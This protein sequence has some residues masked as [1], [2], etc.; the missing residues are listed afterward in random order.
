[1]TEVLDARALLTLMVKMEAHGFAKHSPVPTPAFEESPLSNFKARTT[2]LAMTLPLF[3][4]RLPPLYTGVPPG[5]SSLYY[6]K[7]CARFQRRISPLSFVTKKDR[8]VK[9]RRYKDT[10]QI[11]PAKWEDLARDRAT[12][13]RTVKT[14]AAIHEA[15]RVTAAKTKREARRSQL[16]LH[17]TANARPPPV[18]PTMSAD[19]P[20]TNRSYWT[21]A[22][23]LQHPDDTTRCP[24]VHLCLVSHS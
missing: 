5:V 4:R 17:R 14:G 10:L 11:N 23:Q 9:V 8:S 22:N 2:K 7:F 13:W 1:M 15:N 21:T 12:R 3:N 24:R 6:A 19:V 20:G 18:L 16:R